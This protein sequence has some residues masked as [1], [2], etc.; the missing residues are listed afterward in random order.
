[1]LDP[2]TWSQ[3]DECEYKMVDMICRVYSGEVL[4]D[5]GVSNDRA[6]AGDRLLDEALASRDYP[7]L[8]ELAPRLRAEGRKRAQQ[9]PDRGCA[10]AG[11]LVF[12]VPVN[13]SYDPDAFMDRAPWPRPPFVRRRSIPAPLVDDQGIVHDYVLGV[14]Y[15]PRTHF[16]VEVRDT[17]I[18]G[19]PRRAPS[20]GQPQPARI[21][22]GPVITGL[23]AHLYNRATPRS[24]MA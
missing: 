11:E 16:G 2:K 23:N 10:C 5:D 21:L 1:M 24:P 9:P 14:G 20:I 3:L 17:S 7:K 8:L 18:D 13:P 15:R 12:P 19:I 22:G 6:Q 4:W